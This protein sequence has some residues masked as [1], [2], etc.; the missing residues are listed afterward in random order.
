MCKE[1]VG[2]LSITFAINESTI[3]TESNLAGFRNTWRNRWNAVK[4]RSV[5][6]EGLEVEAWKSGIVFDEQSNTKTGVHTY[7]LIKRPISSVFNWDSV[8][9]QL[10]SVCRLNQ[11]RC[12]IVELRFFELLSCSAGAIC[13][14]VQWIRPTNSL[15]EFSQQ[16]FSTNSPGSF[17]KSSLP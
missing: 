7:L 9:I 1:A 5:F 2:C 13:E 6:I 4:C 14:L 15:N 12:R 17:N 8:G 11:W 3:Q 10:N 16:I